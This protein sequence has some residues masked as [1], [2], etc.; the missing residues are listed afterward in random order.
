MNSVIDAILSRTRTVMTLLIL[1][2]LIG[3][4]TYIN[5][6]KEAQPDIQVPV[7]FVSIPYPGISPEDAERLLIKPMEVRLRTLEGLEKMTS[8]GTTD[9]AGIVLEF[10]MDMDMDQV[11]IDVREQVALARADIPQEA[12]EPY[13]QEIN[14]AEEP[15][16]IAAIFGDVPE[17]TMFTL[18]R[19]A[20]DKVEGIKS[21]LKADMLGTREELVEVVIDPA[22]L[23]GYNIS[24]QELF[25]AVQANNRVIP[26][27]S[28]D[29]GQGAF[30]VKV[31]G[32]FE[33]AQDIF[34]LVV[35]ESGD[36]VVVLSDV[37]EIRRTF[38]DRTGFARVNGQ[39]AYGLAVSKRIG[40][41]IVEN[42]DEVKRVLD[43]LAAT[44]PE[45]V[46]VDYI[47]DMSTYIDDRIN[48][49]QGSI[50]TAI[51]LVM[52]IVVAALGFR[53]AALV[54]FAI[55]SSFMMAFILL[56]MTGITINFMV[57]F[58]LVLAVGILVDGAIVV[59]EY[60]DRKMAEGLDKME[61]FG[62]AAKRM[63]WPIV[64]ST[65]TTLAAFFPMLFW[66]GVSGEFMSYLPITMIFVLG[67]SLVVALVFLPVTGAIFGKASDVGAEALASLSA[68]EQGDPRDLPGYTGQYARAIGKMIKTPWRYIASAV[69]LVVIIF[70]AFGAAG[71]KSEFFITADPDNATILVKARGN[72]S[73][74]E[75]L[76]MVSQVENII[77]EIPGVRAT[78]ASTGSG[79]LSFSQNQPV[80]MIGN[81]FIE[82]TDYRTRISGKEIL[83]EIRNRTATLPGMEVQVSE[84]EQGPPV[85]KDVQVEVRSDFGDLLIPAVAKIADYM[86]TQVPGLIEFEDTRPLPG[87]EYQVEVDREKAGQFGADTTTIGAYVQLITNGILVGKMRPD[88]AIDEVDIRVRFPSDARSFDSLGNLKIRTQRGQVPLSNFVKIVPRPKLDKVDRVD[89]K[90]IMRATANT[91]LG[92]NTNEQVAQL[93]N[94][95]ATEANLDPRLDIVFRGASEEQAESADFLGKAMIG[96]LFL[97]AMILLT[98]FNSFYHSVII[99]SSVIL[100]TV[101][102]MLGIIVTGQSF[103]IIMTGTGIVALAGIVVNNNIVLIDTFQRFMREGFEVEQAII[104]TASQRLRP[105]LLTT[106][107]TIFGLLPMAFG[108]SV[109]YFTREM[110]LGSPTSMFWVQLSTAVCFGLAFST[111]LTLYLTPC[112]LMAPTKL[113]I[114]WLTI[115]A[116]FRWIFRKLTGRGRPAAAE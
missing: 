37:A 16:I 110:T 86:K 23:E 114:F 39:P 87:I 72:Y 77:L 88:D 101:G 80:D 22:K 56:S 43:E 104:S 18:A 7:A 30:N 35:R 92:F 116:P 63:F 31:P 33:T 115:T 93:Q 2:V 98:Q 15:V 107:T 41:N 38:K 17:R 81:I 64:S 108:L 84:I 11:L 90:R 91:K 61:A 109:N 79:G 44:W 105:I 42:N 89:G 10:S 99:L 75:Q 62:L 48:S 54:G 45:N 53:S 49:L 32:T 20:K 57:M 113:K 19:R 40:E 69:G 71:V 78:F 95:I 29:T 12:E 52:I 73:A 68:E 51:S 111:I 6:P 34:S 47:F 58:G 27:G 13:V 24:Y 59:V 26:A 112:L 103:S 83:E 102:V 97:M 82:L 67:A 55:P 85:G 36:G 50:I 76:Q 106:T 46:K 21:V 4:S 25:N 1:T 65:G 96:S 5:I 3:F 94:W 70:F 14:L 74:E 60:A 28:L 9:H 8:Y 66:P 100:S